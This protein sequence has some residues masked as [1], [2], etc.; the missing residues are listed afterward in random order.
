MSAN[1]DYLRDPG[2]ITR[3]SFEI[4]RA[5]VD[6]SALPAGLAPVAQR[7]VHACGT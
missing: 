6:V 1:F 2:E 7:L 4:L 3:R 5:E